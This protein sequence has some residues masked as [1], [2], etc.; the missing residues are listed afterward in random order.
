M[1]ADVEGCR[2]KA[3]MLT[4][5]AGDVITRNRDGEARHAIILSR[6]EERGRVFL[7]ISRFSPLLTL[8]EHQAEVFWEPAYGWLTDSSGQI[9]LLAEE[10]EST[11]KDGAKSFLS[12]RCMPRKAGMPSE[13][14]SEKQQIIMS[15]MRD[16]TR[17]FQDNA[18]EVLRVLGDNS[19]SQETVELLAYAFKCMVARVWDL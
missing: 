12:S 5:D 17:S 6:R 18:V 2:F 4:L 19:P 13:M 15:S 16:R 11:D 10:W 14:P 7:K 3:S 9:L 1:S 8:E